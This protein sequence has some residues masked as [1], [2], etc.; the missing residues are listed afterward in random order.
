MDS[1]TEVT[2]VT[3]EE[4]VGSIEITPIEEFFVLLNHPSLGTAPAVHR[5]SQG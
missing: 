1:R 2:A 4:I 5:V 3:D